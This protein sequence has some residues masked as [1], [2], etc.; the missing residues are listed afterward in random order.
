[1]T[2]PK[3]PPTI[4]PKILKK[5]TVIMIRARAPNT[6]PTPKDKFSI[7]LGNQKCNPNGTEMIIPQIAPIN[8]DK[9]FLQIILNTCLKFM[10]IV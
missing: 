1:M 6:I 10:F 4:I 2:I 5:I 3:I 9:R 7:C 8:A